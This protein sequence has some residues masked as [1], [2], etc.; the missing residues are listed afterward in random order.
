MKEFCY[1]K[2]LIKLHYK[3]NQNCTFCWHHQHGDII[4]H[5]SYDIQSF[6]K[7]LNEAKSLGLEM[8]ILTGGEPTIHKDFIKMC[9]LVKKSNLRLALATN[10]S[11][12]GNQDLFH[13]LL[14]YG[15]DFVQISFYSHIPSDV[16]KITQTN[17]YGSSLKGI[18]N[19]VTNKIP[20]LVHLVVNSV[21]LGYLEEIIDFLNEVGVEN[22]KLNIVE[23]TGNA[24]KYSG[25]IPNYVSAVDAISKAMIYGSEKLNMFY[26]G[27]PLC[28]V[29]GFE[30]S[31]LDL[32]K[33]GIYYISEAFED[34]F[35]SSHHG[36]RS[37]VSICKDC[38]KN[39]NCDGIYTS[40]FKHSDEEEILKTIHPYR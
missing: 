39:V 21:N 6:Q 22:I 16:K 5:S 24:E 15:L 17:L 36:N 20:T 38:M 7:R 27:L 8:V 10:A 23:P 19:L 3:C 9:S 12:L 13:K 33:I 30:K 28:S 35:Y 11:L 18:T 2:G 31:Y 26:D 14:S 1:K 25:I 40:Y 34:K 4:N 37:K 32:E 29:Y